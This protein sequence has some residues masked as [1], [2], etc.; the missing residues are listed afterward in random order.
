M[1]GKLAARDNGMNGQE[2]DREEIF[3]IHTIIKIDT[4]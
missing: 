2:G 4:D 1:M 3:M